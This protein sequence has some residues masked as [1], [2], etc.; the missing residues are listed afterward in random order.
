LFKVFYPECI[1]HIIYPLCSCLPGL[2]FGI[3]YPFEYFVGRGYIQF[4]TYAFGDQQA[5]I[6][7]ALGFFGPVERYGYYH[8]NR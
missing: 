5:L 4:F 1:C 3:A 6:V 8:I 7:T 2:A